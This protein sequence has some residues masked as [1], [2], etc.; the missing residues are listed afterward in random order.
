MATPSVKS[1]P[2]SVAGKRY[3]AGRVRGWLKKELL[4]LF[5]THAARV[6]DT[7][8]PDVLLLGVRY[9]AAS[10]TTDVRPGRYVAGKSGKMAKCI[11]CT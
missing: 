1:G 8:M 3:F 9:V 10:R 6:P 11:I 5:A 7:C 2:R 4:K